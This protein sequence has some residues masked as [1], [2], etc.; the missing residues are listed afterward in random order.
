[1]TFASLTFLH[2]ADARLD[3]PLEYAGDVPTHLLEH[4]EDATLTA[5]E[6]AIHTAIDRQVDFV[7]L[8][9]ATFIETD[10]SL[11]AR[12]ALVDGLQTLAAEDIPVY[13]IPSDEAPLPTWRA[14]P[15][16]PEN[17]TICEAGAT[18]PVYRDHECIATVWTGS[19]L[20]HAVPYV[21]GHTNGAT[22]GHHRHVSPFQIGVITSP[23][24]VKS[25]GR[26][27]TVAE[28]GSKEPADEI[29][30]QRPS[31]ARRSSNIEAEPTPSVEE[32]EVV[33]ESTRFNFLTWASQGERFRSNL[34]RQN[35]GL[36]IVDPLTTQPLKS[37]ERTRC[38]V[39]LVEVRPDGQRHETVLPTSS[40]QFQNYSIQVPK[41]IT[42]DDLVTKMAEALLEPSTTNDEDI[43]LIQWEL[44]GNGSLWNSLRDRTTRQNLLDD[45]V[46]TAEPPEDPHLCHAIQLVRSKTESPEET[47]TGR[48]ASRLESQDSLT[49]NELTARLADH[50]QAVPEAEQVVGGRELLESMLDTR[51]DTVIRELAWCI[52]NDWLEREANLDK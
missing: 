6:L 13:V 43:L 11:R 17:V 16:L 3:C 37:S 48:F 24:F 34:K 19:E 29:D 38:G 15:E 28:T 1:M 49:K 4:F 31:W 2:I 33:K 9:G 46:L 20:E 23:L 5:F 26:Q 10:L 22:N 52:G 47:L 44:R 32:P 39:K 50:W 42:R 27:N 7:L 35:Q 40:V 30:W 25:L 36:S 21:N 41:E 8:S 45:V 14:I 18:L 12:I 51:D